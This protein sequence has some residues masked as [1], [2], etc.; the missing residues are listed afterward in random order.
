MRSIF[1]FIV[2][3]IGEKYNNTI[4]VGKNKLILN[5]GYED[6]KFINRFAEVISAP[7]AFEYL[8]NKGDTILVHHNVFRTWYDVRGKQKRSSSYINEDYSFCSIDQIYLVK[9]K[10]IWK[11]LPDYCFVAPIHNDNTIENKKEKDLFGIIK[12]NNPLL[13]SQ[14][15]NSG[16]LVSFTPSSEFEFLVDEK[17]LY[18]IKIKDITATYGHPKNEIEYNPSWRKSSGG[19][20]KSS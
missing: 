4:S 13:E 16:D 2:K 14:D 3:P 10:S 8:V 12:I 17:K 5:T 15:I 1:N 11:P 9:S 20:S 18:R 19:V 7:L 6:H